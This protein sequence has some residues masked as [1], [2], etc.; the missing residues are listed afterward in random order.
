MRCENA[1][2][3]SVLRKHGIDTV[4]DL[5]MQLADAKV[6][7]DV[8]AGRASA[9]AL[10][11]CF[12]G[13]WPKETID[14]IAKELVAWFAATGYLQAEVPH[15]SPGEELRISAIFIDTVERLCTGAK[16]P[17]KEWPWYAEK[18][19]VM[20][21]G[22]REIIERIAADNVIDIEQ[23]FAQVHCERVG[24]AA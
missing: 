14:R 3:Q 2:L 7:Y 13:T 19:G 8:V 9:G 10:M 11:T 21:L 17:Q 23:L 4:E 12:L 5:D 18:I 24:C 15:E 22:N 20:V 6:L 1:E 16:V